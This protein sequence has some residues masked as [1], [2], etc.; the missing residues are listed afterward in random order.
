M[1]T[2]HPFL[3]TSVPGANPPH[4][5]WRAELVRHPTPYA[6]LVAHKS[7]SIWLSSIPIIMRQIK[8]FSR[9]SMHCP[10]QLKRQYASNVT[11]TSAVRR[12]QGPGSLAHSSAAK[13]FLSPKSPSVGFGLFFSIFLE[14]NV[15][16]HALVEKV[17]DVLSLG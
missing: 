5:V 11:V 4:S 2:G 12:S 10:S 17:Q 1:F 16:H 3:P 14:D 13:S 8:C 7:T 9:S 15:A 6:T